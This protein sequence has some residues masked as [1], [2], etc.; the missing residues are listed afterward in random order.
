M[1]LRVQRADNTFELNRS[2]CRAQK[3]Q[4]VPPDDL[5]KEPHEPLLLPTATCYVY[6]LLS[7]AAHRDVSCSLEQR[8]NIDIIMII[9]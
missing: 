3:A 2:L 5:I 8:H 7:S 6:V 9:K 1:I 4:L